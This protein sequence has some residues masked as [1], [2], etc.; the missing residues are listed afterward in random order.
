MKRHALLFIVC[1][2]AC[3][4]LFY[5]CASDKPVWQSFQGTPTHGLRAYSADL[6]TND[7]RDGT[8]V[9]TGALFVAQDALRYEMQG[10]GPLE[11][12]ILLARLDSGQ[13]WL[14]N[15]ANNRYMDGSFAP[16]RWMDIRYLLEAFPEVAHPRIIAVNEELL[17]KEI[18]HGYKV[19]KIRRT[20]RSVL[21]GEEKDF[22]E[23]FWLAEESCI[24]LRHED[25]TARTELTNI[26]EQAL[27]ESLFTLPSACRKVSSFV[28]LLQ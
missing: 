21:F 12:M 26:R 6:R 18:L 19:S 5:A 4:A 8:V 3:L 2:S 7:I 17:G 23:L 1:L 14:V 22:T 20:G 27:A 16:Q 10:T 13:A 11:R 24:P 28:E 25:G 9:C 15:P